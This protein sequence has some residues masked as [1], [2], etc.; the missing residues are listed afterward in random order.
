[1]K[2]TLFKISRDRLSRRY[3]WVSFFVAIT[4]LSPSSSWAL[5][6]VSTREKDPQILS[7]LEKAL[8]E[9][10]R[11]LSRLG[12]RALAPSAYVFGTFSTEGRLA[13]GH[14]EISPKTRPVT[15]TESHQDP[16]AVEQYQRRV[17]EEYR[18]T[19][20]LPHLP[21]SGMEEVAEAIERW[22]APGSKP[23]QH[24]NLAKFLAKRGEKAVEEFVRLIE[25]QKGLAPGGLGPWWI[26][27]ADPSEIPKPG[28]TSAGYS[29]PS[30][31]EAFEKERIRL[32]AEVAI[33]R[34]LGRQVVVNVGLG[35]VGSAVMIAN[36][37]AEDAQKNP[38]YFALGYQRPSTES[39]YRVKYVNQGRAPIRTADPT[40]E[41][42]L[43]RAIHRGNIRA[44]FLK[45]AIAVA[46]LIIVD[47]ELHVRKLV[48]KHLELSRA[49]P[50]P[51]LK[52]LRSVG[53]LM[54]KDATVIIE[55][56]VYPGFTLYDALPVLNEALQRRELLSKGEDA[57]LAYTFQRLKPGPRL[58]D[59][60]MK[61]ERIGAGVTPHARD[62]L[63]R[64]YETVGFKYQIWDEVTAP[65]FIK[66]VENAYRF[67]LIELMAAFLRGAEIAGVNAFDVIEAIASARPKTHGTIRFA[68]AL[69]VGGYCIPKELVM[70]IW[71]LQSHFGLS[72]LEVQ[73][74]FST[75]LAAAVAS[76]FRAES[77][78][79]RLVESL[80]EL[81]KTIQESRILW[82][83]VAYNPGVADT[84][85]SGTE[86]GLR[87]AAHYGA[88]NEVTDPYVRHWPELNQQHL[89]DPESWGYGL[90]NQEGLRDVKVQTAPNPEE[91]DPYATV[92]PRLDAIVLATRHPQYVGQG[93]PE[94][95][96]SFGVGRTKK[97]YPGLD[98]VKVVARAMG[99]ENK[100][101]LDTFNFL[102]DAD[103]KTFLALGWTVR[104]FGK[105]H[106]DRLAREVTLQDRREATQRLL[107]ELSSLRGRPQIVQPELEEAIQATSARLE[108]L[109]TLEMNL[110]ETPAGRLAKAR[111]LLAKTL[112][113]SRYAIPSQL[114]LLEAKIQLYQAQLRRLEVQPSGEIREVLTEGE[115]QRL[116]EF[117]RRV[118]ELER[119]R[120]QA[121]LGWAKQVMIHPA[122]RK[123]GAALQKV[124]QLLDT[125]RI[126]DWDRALVLPASIDDAVQIAESYLYLTDRAEG[127]AIDLDRAFEELVHPEA[128]AV[129]VKAHRKASARP[130]L[131][132]PEEEIAVIYRQGR[133]GKLKQLVDPQGY[134]N[135]L[136]VKTVKDM[137]KGKK[138]I[139]HG[140][141]PGGADWSKYTKVI[142][143][144]L[145]PAKDIHFEA[146]PDFQELPWEFRQWLLT[147]VIGKGYVLST[148]DGIP[149]DRFG[150]AMDV[151]L[152]PKTVARGRGG[153]VFFQ[154]TRQPLTITTD[155]GKELIVDLK[156]VGPYE[157]G[158][159]AKLGYTFERVT[160]TGML[161]GGVVA[162]MRVGQVPG[163]MSSAE[164]IP[165]LHRLMRTKEAHE[166]LTPRP[167][168][169]IRWKYRDGPD[170][171]FQMV[172]RA[173]PTNQRIGQIFIGGDE[174]F[175]PQ[176]VARIMGE[177]AAR[178]LTQPIAGV[179][180]GLNGDNI[181]ANGHY[182]DLAGLIDL[183]NE[184]DPYAAFYK[185]FGFYLQLVIFS[186]E[187]IARNDYSSPDTR[188]VKDWLT[189][190]L[191][192]FLTAEEGQKVRNPERFLSFYQP[193]DRVRQPIALIEDLI[194]TIWE[195]Y[196]PY[197]LLKNRLDYGYDPTEESIYSTGSTETLYHP[198]SKEAALKFIQ[199]QQAMLTIAE[200]LIKNEG[201]DPLP[202][203]FDKAHQELKGKLDR[204]DAI[205]ATNPS[206]DRLAYAEIYR[207]SFYPKK[208]PE[209]YPV[210]SDIEAMMRRE[211]AIRLIQKVAEPTIFYD[212]SDVTAQAQLAAR[213]AKEAHEA[214]RRAEQESSE[215][216][217]MEEIPLAK[218]VDLD[219]IQKDALIDPK[220]RVSQIHEADVVAIFLQAGRGKRFEES[221]QA[222]AEQFPDIPKVAYPLKGIPLG[223]WP[224]LDLEK[225]R[226]QWPVISVVGHRA[227]EV[228]EAFNRWT[229]KGIIFIRQS[230]PL[231][232]GHALYHAAAVPGLKDSEKIVVAVAGDRPLTD[233]EDMAKA[234][235]EF[236][237]SKA[238]LLLGVVESDEPKGRVIFRDGQV[239]GILER[240]DLEAMGE[241][242]MRFGM[243]KEELRR[244]RWTNA[245]M[246]VI[247]AKELF[248]I[249]GELVNQNE[250]S[251]YYVTDLV[252]KMAQ[253]G[254]RIVAFPMDP[255]K[256]VDITTIS[257]IQKLERQLSTGP[258]PSLRQ[259]RSAFEDIELAEE[260]LRAHYPEEVIPSKRQQLLRWMEELGRLE[261]PEGA[262]AFPL[263]RAT[264]IARTPG[265]A[266][267]PLGGR[268]V[269]YIG[270]MGGSLGFP[271]L[272]EVVAFVQVADGLNGAVEVYVVDAP[273]PAIKQAFPRD[274]KGP[275]SLSLADDLVR[276][277]RPPYRPIRTLA[278]WDTWASQVAEQRRKDRYPDK[279]INYADD[280]V[281]ALLAFLRTD[282]GDPSLKARLF[283][284]QLLR[285]GKGLRIAFA[286][287]LASGGGLSSSSAVLLA[288]AQALNA[289]GEI[290]LDTEGLIR[291]G[292]AERFYVGTQGGVKDHAHMMFEP[293]YL[294]VA[295]IRLIER[296][297][298][299]PGVELVLLDSGIT[300]DNA[301]SYSPRLNEPGNDEQNIKGRT[302]IG[303][304]LGALWI[305]QHHPELEA[306]LHPDEDPA[307]PY[308]FL[309]E[310]LPGGE[311]GLDTRQ[312]Y[313]IL[314]GIPEKGLTRK[315]LYESLP[316]FSKELDALFEGRPD[317]PSPYALREMVLFGLA[318][319]ARAQEA[320]RLLKELEKGIKPTQVFEQAIEIMQ[321]AHNGDR[322]LH[323][324]IQRLPDG[325]IDVQKEP[326]A[327]R[328][329]D[330]R[331]DWLIANTD[332][333]EAALWRQPG[334]L[335]RSIEP[336][337]LLVDL[338]AF[339]NEEIRRE[340]GRE[341]AAGV[342]V[343]AGLGGT[344]GLLVKEKY[345]A[346]LL[347]F[348]ETHYF[349]PSKLSHAPAMVVQ[350]GKAASVLTYPSAFAK[351]V[352]GKPIAGG[353]EETGSSAQPFAERRSGEE[354]PS[355]DRWG[356][357]VA[358]G[359][360]GIP[361]VVL[362]EKIRVGG[363]L[364][365]I[366]NGQVAL[367]QKG[368]VPDGV[369]AQ[370]L[371]L[372]FVVEDL[373]ED[374]SGERLIGE[375]K[376]ALSEWEV[377]VLVV[378]EAGFQDAIK[379]LSS[380]GRVSA[381][382]L[383]RA[384]AQDLGEAQL[385]AYLLKVVRDYPGRFLRLKSVVQVG[386][387]EFDFL[388]TQ[389]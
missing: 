133:D 62:E 334:W 86:R 38:V 182:T 353:L 115:T 266:P 210:L 331:L 246:Y 108:Y 57:N 318:E 337:D 82:M 232:T 356:W 104:G 74:I 61:L 93:Q 368:L 343:G 79:Y 236:M 367:L 286:S 25:V 8:K 167:L 5:R 58:M 105:G 365:A 374:L 380:Y 29:I 280:L 316:K 363:S 15:I 110:G 282:F 49:D 180:E 239:V 35:F 173:S 248:S 44:T 91:Y 247:R 143:L 315:E 125:L 147:E 354:V 382:L 24:R 317:P 17:A 169:R 16:D 172:A 39:Y 225:R 290:G 77:A 339:F 87:L 155:E 217:G 308:G 258:F 14:E 295:P 13:S 36:A 208:V 45:E 323:H 4:L 69:Q 297:P 159:P 18:R 153:I 243:T 213:R 233:A 148:M 324:R 216:A 144:N 268:H 245:S 107:Q 338:V 55:T 300:R 102:S 96:R 78:V 88:K 328:V 181:M 301:Q 76:D 263:D 351:D 357:K 121:V 281:A 89:G 51:T 270:L 178:I 124:A 130:D 375:V 119:Q 388:A 238:D 154:D 64:Y 304:A 383:D 371:G 330:A 228:M 168:F 60:L 235:E 253:M 272:Q 211:R 255:A 59:S 265:R 37:Q 68:P 175:E 202:F 106:I 131:A 364:R 83:G 199:D 11:D 313:E 150:Y 186:F 277:N 209:I 117:A 149:Q 23:R 226:P 187:E 287:D 362:A 276:P 20:R 346:P 65:E 73:Q 7:G 140:E 196:L 249:L 327:W 80:G 40:V 336:I 72:E 312:I 296:I 293:G 332:Q 31:P 289:L 314:R 127:L 100:I 183:F 389:L 116:D 335:E 48:P 326:W 21:A 151:N 320:A 189:G 218:R 193:G 6:E 156:A 70:V 201:Y 234:V 32:M 260:I 2:G 207:L 237:G 54:P 94:E 279:K 84:R 264:V 81:G 322:I 254:K 34:A 381:V 27:P 261:T 329:S 170:I 303:Y 376:R 307:N 379:G 112:M 341:A 67:G 257:D 1:V 206:P 384:L 171:E 164:E 122:R 113:E 347:E 28:L 185:Y 361:E 47:T 142:P 190:F 366:E 136:S 252:E 92:H 377:P 9:E 109:Q 137:A 146:Y 101:V 271:I 97:V 30:T 241:G 309:R 283:L 163:H 161:P 129:A 294:G 298:T 75:R 166:G 157:G 103:I 387:E 12:H 203:D 41:R 360:D 221:I 284:D 90:L 191:D 214:N 66:D 56:T 200:R 204:I 165:R 3:R 22:F 278:E 370:L 176:K 321:V 118:E 50:G 355:A 348:L 242:E 222:S 273:D 195:H 373:P 194:R 288:A 291:L 244:I 10:E 152:D 26:P 333:P 224:I 139:P 352:G 275:R 256:A 231:G 359:S 43:K 285:E 230:E 342:I 372:G 135:R 128:K 160:S 325:T 250:Q 111:Y 306:G 302:G 197:Q 212:K 358:I 345:R 188:Y 192:V 369:R 386:L 33:Q 53:S 259:W 71:G 177:N 220:G 251:E 46:D 350:P 305:R 311:I 319:S 299:I 274:G 215:R 205:A 344:V 134:P 123:L 145:L 95:M 227:D 198:E 42:W 63:R 98:P 184:R 99:L 267:L 174:D 310:L 162:R 138:A 141:V 120:K 126:L 223:M 229:D 179:H 132:F 19:G 114:P 52:L 158:P 240:Q 269:D 349:G 385:V 340:S 262:V 219:R 378:A 292:Y 85:Y